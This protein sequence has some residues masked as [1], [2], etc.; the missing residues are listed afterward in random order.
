MVPVALAI[1]ITRRGGKERKN[2]TGF[3]RPDPH[4][5][6]RTPRARLCLADPPGFVAFCSRGNKRF[7]CGTTIDNNR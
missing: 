2:G 6:R 3:E 5:G 1:S 7:V 4:G